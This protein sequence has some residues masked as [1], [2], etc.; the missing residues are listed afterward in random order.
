MSDYKF[1]VFINSKRIASGTV[2][3]HVRADGW[4]ALLR[5]IANTRKG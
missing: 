2:N 4:K 5:M 3:G 1:D